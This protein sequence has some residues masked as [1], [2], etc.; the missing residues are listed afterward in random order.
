M[1]E[2]RLTGIVGQAMVFVVFFLAWEIAVHVF[3]MKAVILPPPSTTFATMWAKRAYLLEHT[4]PTVAAIAV[5][6]LVPAMFFLGAVFLALWA[7][8][9]LLGARIEADRARWEAAGAGPETPH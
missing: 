7:T 2:R 4:W 5:G 8:A 9:Y 6:F 3:D 1:R